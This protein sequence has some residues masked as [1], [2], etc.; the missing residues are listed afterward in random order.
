MTTENPPLYPDIPVKDQ[1][2]TAP[3]Y[4]AQSYRLQDVARW[5]DML[6]QELKRRQVLY[7]KYKRAV[8]WVEGIET[9]LIVGS[10]GFGVGGAGFLSTVVAS[11]VG[12]GLEICSLI[13]ACCSLGSKVGGR[14]LRTKAR[15]HD[16]LHTL[17]QTK[18]LDISVHVSKA[19][20]D[21]EISETEYQY[22]TSIVQSYIKERDEIRV[23]S[24]KKHSA[25]I[26]NLE[27]VKK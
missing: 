20:V 21:G 13:F 2:P 17:A 14:L 24:K 22:V 23:N 6:T 5:R 3:L 26:L 12:L 4:T 15:K 19:L 16:L 27:E 11:P 8:N 25:I 7:Q 18:L 9:T 1:G 10:V